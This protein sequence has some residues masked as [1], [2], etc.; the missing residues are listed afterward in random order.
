MRFSQLERQMQCGKCGC[1]RHYKRSEAIHTLNQWI[2][3]LQCHPP[4]LREPQGEG[5]N[6]DRLCIAPS[7]HSAPVE[8]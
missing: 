5:M 8:G 3:A 6:I 1:L 2:A 7:P 4:T